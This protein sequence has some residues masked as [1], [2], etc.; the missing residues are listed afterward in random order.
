[1]RI[2]FFTDTYTPQINGVVTSIRLFKTRPRGTRPR[3]LRVRPHT[4]T[5]RKTPTTPSASAR[6][7]SSSSPRCAWPRP[8]RSRP[9][10][11]LDEIELDVVHAHDPFAIGLFGLRSPGATRSRTCTPTTRSTP[12]TCTTS[13]R[14]ASP[15][16]SPSGSRASTASA[17]DSIVAPSTKVED[18]L[19]D[20]GVKAPD[21]DHRDRCRRREVRGGRRGRASLRC[22]SGCSSSPKTGLPCSWG[23]SAGRRTSRRSI[24]AL[25]HCRCPDAQARHLR[26]R[27]APRGARG[28]GRRAVPQEPRRLRRLPRGQGHRRRVPSRAHLRVR[29]DHRDAGARHRRSDGR[30]SAGR[31]RERQGGRG[32][33][34]RRR[35]RA[36]RPRA[37]GGSRPRVRRAARR[38]AAPARVL[39][40]LRPRALASSRSHAKPRSSSVTTCA[41]SRC[42]SRTR[43]CLASRA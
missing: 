27:T 33:R 37:P 9:C 43:S 38:R 29:L 26:R 23:G 17:C 12:S 18:Y 20:W 19:R 34:G 2:G 42:T 5:R 40:R 4:R 1:M 22:A 15:R 30:R 16:S 6:C 28:P 39:A 13:G 8:S 36:G 21:R 35:Q 24:R 3:G 7:P 41:T 25:W 11:S 14:R 31:R 10:D 32:L